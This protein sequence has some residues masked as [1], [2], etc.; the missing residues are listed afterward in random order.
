MNA[1]QR[2]LAEEWEAL[3]ARNS[4]P[5]E[6]GSQTLSKAEAKKLQ[7][8]FRYRLNSQP[9]RA[10]ADL[11]KH[12]SKVTPGGNATKPDKPAYT[13]DAMVGIAQMAKSNAVPVFDFQ[14]VKDIGKMRR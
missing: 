9:V 10:G 8:G 14:H 4:K 3:K 1:K 5:L 12:P 7:A 11:K 6:K 13:G 2:K